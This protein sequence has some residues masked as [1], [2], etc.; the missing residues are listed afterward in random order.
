MALVAPVADRI[1]LISSA[2]L[3]LYTIHLAYDPFGLRPI[4]ASG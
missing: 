1:F 4:K 3:G 2:L